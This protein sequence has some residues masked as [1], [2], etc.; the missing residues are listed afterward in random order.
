MD[1]NI[2]FCHIDFSK[3][4]SGEEESNGGSDDA[5]PPEQIPGPYCL[6]IIGSLYKYLPLGQFSFVLL[7]D[8]AK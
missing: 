6:P 3:S 4:S 8:Y 5:L 7:K 2:L 1:C